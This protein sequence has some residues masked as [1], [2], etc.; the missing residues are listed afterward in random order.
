[1]AEAQ[2]GRGETMMF[3]VRM[4]MFVMRDGYYY[5]PVQNSL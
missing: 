5:A 2:L 1:M 3:D 4:D